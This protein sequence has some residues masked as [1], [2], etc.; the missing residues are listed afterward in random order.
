MSNRFKSGN[1]QIGNSYVLPIEQSRV[2][3]QEVKVKKILEETD[4]RAKEILD[5]AENKSQII[6]NTASTERIIE[7]SRKK[8]QNDYDSVKQEAYKEGFAKGEEDGLEKFKNDAS[9]ALKSLE[10]LV[11]S[12]FE[13]KKNIIDSATLDIVEL[14][15]AIAEKVCQPLSI[16]LLIEPDGSEF[17][18]ED[19]RFHIA[20]ADF[21]QTLVQAF[22]FA[23]FQ[24]RFKGYVGAEIRGCYHGPGQFQ[25][26]PYLF[27][28]TIGA[29]NEQFLPLPHPGDARFGQGQL[30]RLGIGPDQ[31]AGSQKDAA[32]IAGDD[33]EHILYVLGA[34]HGQRG[35]AGGPLGFAI[36]RCPFKFHFIP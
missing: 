32:E 9:D 5:G 4:N 29:G 22:A 13:T 2:T 21:L 33:T 18:A 25:L 27:I 28:H 1:I 19:Q 24:Q 10:T 34:K 8:A 17:T 31:S 36:V 15:S 7:E 11:S 35:H 20:G 26:P 3:M 14:V 16:Y 12:T 23:L 6:V 30:G